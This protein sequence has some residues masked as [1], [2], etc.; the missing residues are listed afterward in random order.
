[1]T[2]AERLLQYVKV[3]TTSD[4]ES[5]TFPGAERHRRLRLSRTL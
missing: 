5:K 3:H 2:A 1:M 4:P